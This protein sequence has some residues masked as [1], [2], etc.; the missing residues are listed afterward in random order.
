MRKISSMQ[1]SKASKKTNNADETNN[2]PELNAGAENTSKPRTVR[3]S[4]TKKETSDTGSAKHRKAS[5]D[6]IG[7][8]SPAVKTQA[9]SVAATSAVSA[10]SPIIDSVG[11]MTPAVDSREAA[12]AESSP[13]REEIAKLAH[14]YWIA[15]GYAHG[16]PEEDWLRA[17]RELRN[18]R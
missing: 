11:V 4:K 7:E 8:S 18:K 14:S 9:A 17:E 1:F 2:Q 16:S 10:D 12:S 6:A 13:S 3:S 15:R 5:P